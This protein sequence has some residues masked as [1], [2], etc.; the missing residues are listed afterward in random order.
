MAAQL[1]LAYCLSLKIFEKMK[2]ISKAILFSTIFFLYFTSILLSQTPAWQ[3]INAGGSVG[4]ASSDDYW[5][6]C[7]SMDSDKNG[8]L[9]GFSCIA[10][11]YIEIDTVTSQAYGYEDLCVFSYRC[12]GSFRWVRFIGTAYNDKPGDIAVDD[13]G[14]VFVTGSVG[15]SQYSDCQIGDSIIPLTTTLSKTGFVAKIDSTGHTLWVN[16]PGPDFA[17]SIPP[18]VYLQIELDHNGFPIAFVRFNGACTYEGFTIPDAGHY[19]LRFDKDTGVLLDI[20]RMDVKKFA[21]GAYNF[22]YVMDTD[23]S[24]Y[25]MMEVADTVVIGGDT[26][27]ADSPVYNTLLARFDSLGQNMWYTEVKGTWNSPTDYF[28]FIWGHPLVYDKYV[29]ISGE[30]E[31]YPGTSF[32]GVLIE[33]PLAD[34]QYTRTRLFARFNKNTGEFVSVINLHNQEHIMS[35]EMAVRNDKI[36]AV[37]SG[38]RL[39]MMNQT[40]TVLPAPPGYDSYP[41]VVEM[42]TALTQFNWGFSAVS[43]GIPKIEVLHVDANHNLYVGGY[44]NGTIYDSYGIPT[45]IIGNEDFFVAK[46]A[47]DN[48]QCGCAYAQPESQLINFDN[49]V[50]QV[51]GTTTIPAD[52]MYWVWGDGDSTLYTTPGTTATHTYAGPGSYTVCLR[53][54]NHCG[55]AQSCLVNLGLEPETTQPSINC[56]PNP[57]ANTLCIE[58]GAELAQANVSLYTLPGELVTRQQLAGQKGN[59]ATAQLPAGVYLIKVVS[60]TGQVYVKKVMKE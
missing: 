1:P 55:M 15:V 13:D 30:T 16:H 9:Y 42:D 60:P 41:F 32:F 53:T 19:A 38:G 48:N 40:D 7:K 14:N 44:I 8:N 56:F 21:G 29:Y 27:T 26:V 57:F 47:I 10:G 51:A 6:G 46:V 23:N 35:A 45:Y 54:W 52:S 5:E 43:S 24:I 3:W 22:F 59:L 33:N 18:V 49:N 17:I 11:S 4:A 20:T 28:N 36:V 50:L 58:V 31:S 34:A 12:D 39:V 25:M 2:K 37:C